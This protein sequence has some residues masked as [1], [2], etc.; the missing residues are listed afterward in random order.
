M[1]VAAASPGFRVGGIGSRP[2]VRG[3]GGGMGSAV[4]A[5]ASACGMARGIRRRCTV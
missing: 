1:V 4:M 5:A 3:M 2:P